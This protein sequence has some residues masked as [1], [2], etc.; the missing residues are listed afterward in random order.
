MRRKPVQEAPLCYMKGSFC[1]IAII[2]LVALCGI[3]EAQSRTGW[4]MHHGLGVSDVNSPTQQ[5]KRFSCSPPSHGHPCEYD[6]QE[7][8]VP[9]PDHA[10][11]VFPPNRNQIDIFKPCGQS[12]VCR[13]PQGQTCRVWGDFT[14]FQTFVDI[15]RNFTDALNVDFANV[16]D[17]A[18]IHINNSTYP[19]STHPQGFMIP[20][21]YVFLGQSKRVPITGY[22]AKGE[23]NRIVVTQV[24]DCCC[25]N[26]IRSILLLVNNT[27]LTP[28]GCQA[29]NDPNVCGQQCCQT[30][31]TCGNVCPGSDRCAGVVCTPFNACHL[32]GVCDPATGQCSNPPAPQ[33]TACDDFDACTQ[34]DVCDGAG[35]CTGTNPVVCTARDQCH[36][37][38][39]CDPATGVCS[40]PQKPDGTVCTDSRPC[41][42]GDACQAGACVS[43]TRD[44]GVC[45]RLQSQC[46]Q[47]CQGLRG[48][49]QASCVQQCANEH[50]ACMAS[51]RPMMSRVFV[52]STYFGGNLGGLAGADA[53]CQSLGVTVAAGTRWI[54]WLS[55]PGM[56]AKD[57]LPG[58][59]G[60]FVRARDTS[61]VIANDINE[62]IS[63][64][65][66][67]PI[68]L[69]EKGNPT[70]LGA[71]PAWTGTD[72]RG[73]AVEPS[74]NRWTTDDVNQ[75]GRIGAA[76]RT[77][78]EWTS[79]SSFNCFPGVPGVTN[80]G[81]R[82][83]CFE[84]P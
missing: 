36:D 53:K 23:E 82:L 10:K 11:W 21:S 37:A 54:A 1:C 31:G 76:H 79:S 40:N 49:N 26:S 18:R 2:G 16:D 57:R 19:L 8:I 42:V 83:Y 84:V 27:P 30:D 7:N 17:G 29:S 15:P 68:V 58:G 34:T 22:L 67:N 41:T 65:L 14:Y 71:N 63:G 61:T 52:T 59:I 46:V 45:G 28:K 12:L 66:R 81:A 75:L 35:V 60:P 9:P 20:N 74:C 70:S 80:P 56:N 33:G 47:G 73:V 5:L 69:D 50:Q 78:R 24:D 51:C 13:A 55:V 4:A 38:G 32:A 48:Q 62:L 25:V 43:G 44:P 77:T 6:A 64:T 3:A 72:E 39:S